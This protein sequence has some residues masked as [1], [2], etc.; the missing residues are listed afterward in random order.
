VA[1]GL[2]PV[3]CGL[4]PVAC[5]L[6]PVACGLW[7]VAC[8]LHHPW[9]GL[10]LPALPSFLLPVASD[11]TRAAPYCSYFNCPTPGW[12]ARCATTICRGSG[13]ARGGVLW[14]INEGFTDPGCS[15]VPPPHDTRNGAGNGMPAQPSLRSLTQNATRTPA[16]MAN[17][18]PSEWCD[19]H[20]GLQLSLPWTDTLAVC[21]PMFSTSH[22]FLVLDAPASNALAM[23]PLS[24]HPLNSPLA[25]SSK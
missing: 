18:I 12:L 5:G 24:N 9:D 15:D 8:G 14:N 22:S 21:F 23:A 17:P 25:W 1:C 11:G 16:T 20:A 19:T 4:W 6:W 2:W 7:P 3:A 13:Y 10:V